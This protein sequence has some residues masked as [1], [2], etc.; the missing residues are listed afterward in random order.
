MK[1][2][3]RGQLTLPRGRIV[4]WP[5]FQLRFVHWDTKHHQKRFST[6]LRMLDWAAFYKV[7][8]IGFELEDKYEY[9]THPVIGAPGAYTKEE[10]QQLTRYALQRH[11][12]LVPVIQSPAHMTYV[13][14]HAEFAHLRADPQ[15]NYQACLCDDEAIRLIFDMYQDVIDATPGVDYFHVSTDEVYFAGMCGKCEKPFNDRNR[16]QAWVDFVKRAHTFLLSKGRTMLAW[17]EW[18]LEAADIAQ[19]PH[20]IID[21]VM[22][23]DLDFLRQQRRIGMRQLAYSSVQGAEELFPNHF[24]TSYRGRRTEGRLRDISGTIPRG[25]RDGARPI[26]SF[27]AAWD[28][29]GLHEE[30]FWLGWITAT[31]YAWTYRWPTLEQSVADFFDTFY[32]PNSSSMVEVYQLLEEGARFYES[33]WDRVLSRERPRA[34][35]DRG[36][37]FDTNH[38]RTDKVLTPPG[39]PSGETLEFELVF[40]G[41]YRERVESARLHKAKND[42]LL[43]LIQENLSRVKWNRYNLEVFL[44]I[45]HFERFFLEMLIELASVEETLVR[46][47]EAAIDHQP[48]DALNQLVSAV[49]RAT[50]LLNKRDRMWQGLVVTWEKSRYPKGR[51]WNGRDYVHGMDDL[52]DHL[53]DRRPGMEYLMAPFERLGLDAWREKLLRLTLDFAAGSG[54]AQPSGVLHRAPQ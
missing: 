3:G 53:A 33:S 26:G 36:R 29:S 41:K 14:K 22:G 25:L 48:E 45:A 11:I 54:L 39:L 17:V 20:G 31:Q 27:A 23:S 32:G 50:E 16:S 5:D 15:S 42:R 6:L 51:S 49:N 9:P 13:L 38:R 28:D 30:T 40:H 35:D 21:G 2:N 12:Q 8:A 19:L 24:P 10:M 44:S 47:S 34:Y 37:R 1:P 7:N 4:D 43:S 46:A 18:P 52:K